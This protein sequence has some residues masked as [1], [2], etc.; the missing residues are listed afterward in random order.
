ML[1]AIT[2]FEVVISDIQA[3]YKLSQNRSD[4]DRKQVIKAL[5]NIGSTELAK[6]MK[7]NEKDS[8]G[9]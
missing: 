4:Q 9:R 7:N 3:Q 6:A 8:F 2:G 5:D 1:G